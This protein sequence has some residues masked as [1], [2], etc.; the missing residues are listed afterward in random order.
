MLAKA[1]QKIPVGTKE[2]WRKIAD[3]V[4]TVHKYDVVDSGIRRNEKDILKQLKHQEIARAAGTDDFAEFQRKMAKEKELALKHNLPSAAMLV[5]GEE[6]R[7]TI[8]SNVVKA[9]IGTV[10]DR[11]DP[12]NWTKEEQ[13]LLEQALRS[14]PKDAADRW[15]QIAR[16]VLTRNKAQCAARYAHLREQVAAK[17]RAAAAAAAAKK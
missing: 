14:V 15:D 3:M 7:A 13:T 6:S 11:D 8:T 5:H 1:T 10:D 16:T 17:K 2:R 9:V 12:T 4:N